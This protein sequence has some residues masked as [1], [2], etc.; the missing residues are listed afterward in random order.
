MFQDEWWTISKKI[1]SQFVVLLLFTITN[2]SNLK[3]NINHIL[4][5]KYNTLQT[6]YIFNIQEYNYLATAKTKYLQ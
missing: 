3:L 1:I 5:T 6:E 2:D 4:N